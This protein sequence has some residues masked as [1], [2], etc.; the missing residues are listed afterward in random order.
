[1]LTRPIPSPRVPENVKRMFTIGVNHAINLSPPFRN[2]LKACAC[3]RNTLMTESGELE[4]SNAA[5]NGCVS[6]SCFVSVLYSF[7]A[8][9]NI[10]V[11]LAVERSVVWLLVDIG[12]GG[13][14]SGGKWGGVETLGGLVGRKLWATSIAP[15][16]D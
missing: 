11:K 14:K 4:F 5:A 15:R 9:S 10:A 2:L 8:A 16:I 1:M 12:G 3:F 6:I 7:D 13:G